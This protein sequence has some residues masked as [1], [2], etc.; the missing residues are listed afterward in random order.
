MEGR[1]AVRHVAHVRRHVTV[2]D[3]TFSSWLSDRHASGHRGEVGPES[4]AGLLES[5]W[6]ATSLRARQPDMEDIRHRSD[7]PSVT[8]RRHKQDIHAHKSCRQV[9][10]GAP[11]HRR[12]AYVYHSKFDATARPMDKKRCLALHERH[13]RA[14]L[15]RR[16]IAYCGPLGEHRPRQDRRRLDSRRID[17]MQSL[18]VQGMNN[19]PS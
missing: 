13:A 17:Q 3:A 7:R 10:S 8:P 1:S 12:Q 15:S 6:S 2:P 14:G 18:A 11:L 4:A 16:C 9:A 5:R 19:H